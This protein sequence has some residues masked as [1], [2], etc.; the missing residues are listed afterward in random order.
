MWGGFDLFLNPRATA[1][2]ALIRSSGL[3][4][5]QHYGVNRGLPTASEDAL[6]RDYLANWQTAGV[7]P[8]PHFDGEAYRQRHLGGATDV[9]PL[10]HFLRTGCEKGLNPWTETAV[11]AWQK[12]FLD[13]PDHA[14]S[15]VAQARGAWPRFGTGARVA[16]HVHPQS[17]IVFHEFQS[18]LVAAFRHLGMSAEPTQAGFDTPAELRIIIAPHDFFYL[19]P[20]I[21]AASVDLQTC[22]LFNTEQIPS[23]W[24]GRCYRFL[25]AAAG[26]LDIN[27]QT[28]ACLSDLGLTVRFLP[29]G[30]IEGFPLFQ[31]TLPVPPEYAVWSGTNAGG[32]IDAHRP[33]SERPIDL[34]WIGSNARRR[35]TFWEGAKPVF[36][37]HASFVRLVNVKGALKADHPDAISGL[38]FAALARQSKIL[39]NVHHFDA[40][41]FE[42]QRLMHFGF[43]QGACVVSETLSQI[44][45]LQ[46]GTHYLQTDIAQLPAYVDWLLRDDEGRETLERVRVQG[47]A[48]TTRLYDLPRTLAALFLGE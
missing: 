34:L 27:L 32:S 45:G 35:Q 30:R 8:A 10:V 47:Q 21:D 11:L 37:Q 29:L 44:P 18:M 15:V 7:E 19:E 33:L 22:I 38:A 1:D 36:D 48:A 25:R 17:H 46:P 28:A 41:Y 43:L 12:P 26:V 6:I 20:R 14:L 40:P 2:V 3:F 39:L 24:F 23:F 16:V 4:D 42:W 13:D 5:P 9:S 31:P